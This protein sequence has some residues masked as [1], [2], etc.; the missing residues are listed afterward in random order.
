[1]TNRNTNIPKANIVIGDDTS[2]TVRLLM[3]MFAEHGN[4]VR[5][6]SDVAFGLESARV[7]PRELMLRKLRMPG[8]D[9]Y[10]VCKVLWLGN[11]CQCC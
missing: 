5:A 9:G 6:A 7:T 2:D 3:G 1:M 10:A 11:G 8:M 4:D